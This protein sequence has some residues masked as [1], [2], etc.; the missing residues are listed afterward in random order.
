MQ[1]TVCELCG[2]VYTDDWD[3]IEE[4]PMSFDVVGDKLACEYCRPSE[5]DAIAAES[6]GDDQS[7]SAGG[8]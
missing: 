4:R 7:A 5:K 2:E 1:Q 8:E 3:D 6:E